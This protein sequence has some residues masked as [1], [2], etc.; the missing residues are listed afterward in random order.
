MTEVNDLNEQNRRTINDWDR[1]IIEEFRAN[2]GNVGG[3]FAGVPLLLLTT[4]GAKVA[5]LVSARWRIC[6]KAGASTFS[7]GIG[8][9][10]PIPVGITT[11]SRILM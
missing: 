11:C 9:R 7:P 5:N 8:A 6:P 3:Q 4:T 1:Q 2:G 10:Q